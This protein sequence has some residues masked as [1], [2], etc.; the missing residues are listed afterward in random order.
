MGHE[1]VQYLPNQRADTGAGLG[2]MVVVNDFLVSSQGPLV[3]NTPGQHS[4][5][6]AQP[7]WRF[8]NPNQAHFERS[9]SGTLR[10]MFVGESM[11]QG[12]FEISSF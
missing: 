9:T 10:E 8:A 5:T 12:H 3:A 2:R 7:H 11:F 6:L 4:L 1:I